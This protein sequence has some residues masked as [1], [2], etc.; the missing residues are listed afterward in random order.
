MVSSLSPMTVAMLLQ[1]CLCRDQS[2]SLGS[3]SAGIR[4]NVNLIAIRRNTGAQ[5]SLRT[6]VAVDE[7]G[8]Q[9]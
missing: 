1:L 9:K 4:R 3:L 7:A 5:T 6:P 8:E 2:H